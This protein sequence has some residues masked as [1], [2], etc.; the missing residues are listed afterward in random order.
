MYRIILGLWIV[1][2]GCESTSVDTQEE[3]IA[4]CTLPSLFE[5]E[6]IH[7]CSTQ[8]LTSQ[9]RLILGKIEPFELPIMTTRGLGSMT[10]E[11]CRD[12]GGSSIEACDYTATLHYPSIPQSSC[13]YFDEGECQDPNEKTLTLGVKEGYL[14]LLDPQ[15]TTLHTLL[16]I[17]GDTE[18]SYALLNQEANCTLYHQE[19]HSQIPLNEWSEEITED[20]NGSCRL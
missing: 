3:E 18:W 5:A 1:L 9:E 16:Y 20:T 14:Y 12:E 2:L 10:F 7:S 8:P 13:Q 11:L 6:G 15:T 17:E 19:E 4:H